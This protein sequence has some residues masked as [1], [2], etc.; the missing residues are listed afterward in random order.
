MIVSL[1]LSVSS[2]ATAS[3]VRMTARTVGEAYVVA[4]PGS[5]GELL[6]RRRLV[7]YVNLGAY[8]LLAPR[9]P[10]QVRRA[11]E[12]GQLHI[13]TSMRLRHDFGSYTQNASPAAS[14]GS[15]HSTIARSTSCS[16]T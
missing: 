13:Q 9:E 3:D 16:A 11:P 8:E 4:L 5:G 14:P 1:G 2:R 12:D 10:D 15:D 6:R 7:Q